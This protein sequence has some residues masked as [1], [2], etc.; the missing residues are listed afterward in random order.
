MSTAPSYLGHDHPLITCMIQADNS[1]RAIELINKGHADGCDAFGFQQEVLPEQE[2]DP[3]II[4]RIFS[5][6]QGKPIYVT[7]YRSKHNKG[8]TDEMLL[9][10]LCTLRQNG[11]TLIDIMG[12]FY[13]PHP[14]QLTEEADAVARQKEAIARIHDLGGEVL[15]SSH[16]MKFIP[17]EEV[18]R[19]AT[20]QQ[21]RGADIAKIV[22]AAHSEEEEW[23]NLRITALLKK[24]LKIPFLFLSGGSHTQLHR[25]VGP[26]LGCCTW[27]TVAEHDMYSTKQQPLCKNIRLVADQYQP[28]SF[29]E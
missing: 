7:N 12:D 6:M 29:R 14:I 25:T 22:T 21:E 17:A 1:A 26:L 9:E 8:K 27:L 10:E 2:R 5:A 20:A 13:A 3:Q 18:L 11:A 15:M 4:R 24:E 23:E 28:S 19:I 16:V